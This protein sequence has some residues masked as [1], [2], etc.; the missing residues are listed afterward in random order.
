MSALQNSY[1]QF[2]HKKLFM[3]ATSSLKSLWGKEGVWVVGGG[4]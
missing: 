2:F 3:E 4:G 1:D